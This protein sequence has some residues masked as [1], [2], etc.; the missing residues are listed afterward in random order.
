MAG[1]R[2]GDA[3]VQGK[4]LS[5]FLHSGGIGELIP[6]AEKLLVLRRVVHD[7]LPPNLRTSAQVANLKS[8]TLI[9]QTSHSAA[10]AKL[11]HCTASLVDGL[12]RK[13]YHVAKVKV[14]VR[15]GAQAEAHTRSSRLLPPTAAAALRRLESELPADAPLRRALDT[16]AKKSG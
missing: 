16:L 4:P 11:K 14:E 6:Q 5:A 15:P 7:L 3:S 13:G 12:A 8:D 10:A 1:F 2:L 9:L